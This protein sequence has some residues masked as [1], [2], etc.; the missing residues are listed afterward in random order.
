MRIL[1][2]ED[3]PSLG[4][5]LKKNLEN[6]H[7]AVDL[8]T[9][10]EDAVALGLSVPYDLIILDILLPELDGFEVCRQ[11]RDHKRTVPILMLTALGEVDHRI[12]GLNLGADD[13]LVKPF[14]EAVLLQAV[15]NVLAMQSA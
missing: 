8:V 9:T 12:T 2:A 14:S 3:N 13:Y 10:G 15:Q 7:Y 11:L 5:N 4:P 1:L 6:Y